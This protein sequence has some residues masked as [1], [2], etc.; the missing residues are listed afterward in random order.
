MNT[1]PLIHVGLA[2]IL[3]GIATLTYQGAS[4]TSRE[5]IVDIDRLQAG[6]GTTK[7]IPLSPLVRG[8]LLGGGIVLVAVGI[9][10]WS[11]RH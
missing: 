2:L 6:A 4:H 8:L 5:K 10:K 9:K 11:W 1:K 7:T 3:L